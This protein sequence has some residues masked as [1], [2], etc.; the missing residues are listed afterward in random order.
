MSC[1]FLLMD[2]QLF[3]SFI[4]SKSFP[5]WFAVTLLSKCS[6]FQALFL[7]SLVYFTT[8]YQYNV[9]LM[10]TFIIGLNTWKS[11]PSHHV[12]LQGRMIIIGPLYFHI[13]FKTRLS[14]TSVEN[15]IEYT[16][17]FREMWYLYG[18]GVFQFINMAYLSIRFTLFS[19]L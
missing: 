11:K 14:K 7:G 10:Y 3:W 13:N 17:Q 8:K 6:T 15:H 1:I 12:F 18:N 19:F 5:H 9:D 4:V 16:H 2:N